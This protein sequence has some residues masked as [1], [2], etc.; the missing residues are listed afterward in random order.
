MKGCTTGSFTSGKSSSGKGAD[1][2]KP[3]NAGK[4]GG[5]KVPIIAWGA[6]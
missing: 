5:S 6:D 1:A 3:A 4:W 2:K